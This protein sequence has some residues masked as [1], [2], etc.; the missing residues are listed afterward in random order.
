M[1]LVKA[2]LNESK[3]E[4]KE[5]SD[6]AYIINTLMPTKRQQRSTDEL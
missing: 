2:S 6:K 1:K 5:N 3:K 4:E